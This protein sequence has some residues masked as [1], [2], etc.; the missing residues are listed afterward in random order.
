MWLG[1]LFTKP[2]NSLNPKFLCS[3][4]YLR[5]K[6]DS[7]NLDDS[8]K[9]NSLNPADT[10]CTMETYCMIPHSSHDLTWTKF[11][12]HVQAD[13]MRVVILL[14]AILGCLQPSCW[15]ICPHQ[16]GTT[17]QR[18]S[19][20]S[21]WSNNKVTRFKAQVIKWWKLLFLFLIQSSESLLVLTHDSLITI[22]HFWISSWFSWI[23]LTSGSSRVA[24][25]VAS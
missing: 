4:K 20:P 16:D 25:Y 5:T 11:H 14:A 21:T 22:R 1:A 8:L 24:N 2:G 9:P 18:W 6:I 12:S 10:V 17:F 13:I 23:L 3:K 15:A 7:L 19:N